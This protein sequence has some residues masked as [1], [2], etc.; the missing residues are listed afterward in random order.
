MI[1]K[2]DVGCKRIL[3]HDHYY[4]IY[5]RNNVFLETEGIKNF[6]ENSITTNEGKTYENIDLIVYA[7]GF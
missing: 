4:E 5:E 7:T 1:P 6:G 3:S 2:Y